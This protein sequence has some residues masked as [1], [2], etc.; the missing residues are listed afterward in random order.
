MH[1]TKVQL[2]IV[3]MLQKGELDASVAMQLLGSGL[4]VAPKKSEGEPGKGDGSRKRPRENGDAADEESP[5]GTL[6]DPQLDELLDQAKKTKND[7][8]SIRSDFFS[9]F[10]VHNCFLSA[11]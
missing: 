3:Q 11:T 4:A 2:R 5:E 7:P 6:N 10:N 9:I 8:L 1:C